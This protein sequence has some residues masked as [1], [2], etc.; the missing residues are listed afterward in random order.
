[1]AVGKYKTAKLIRFFHD[2]NVTESNSEYMWQL[3]QYPTYNSIVSTTENKLQMVDH[4]PDTTN[5]VWMN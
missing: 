3:D 4:V 1:V 5:A 2:L